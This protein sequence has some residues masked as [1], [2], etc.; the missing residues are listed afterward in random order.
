LK[1]NKFFL[2]NSRFST[3]LTF[4]NLKFM[5]PRIGAHV[6]AAGGLYKA[7]E[8][9]QAIGAECIQIFGASP[10]TWRGVLPSAEQVKKFRSAAAAAG[11][12]HIYLHASYLV[13]LASAKAYNREQS[14]LSL[15]D[16]L[17]IAELLGARGLIFH[18][19]SSGVG[20]DINAAKKYTIEGINKIL[21]AVPA[22]PAGGPGKAKL[23][24]ENSAGGGAKLGLTFHQ[25]GELFHGAAS[26]RLGICF[27]TAHGFEAGLIDDYTPEKTK[28][29]FDEF[30]REI[31]LEHLM[32]LHLNDSKTVFGSHHDRHE[33]LG[34]GQIGF[35]GF[36][37][38]ASDKRLWQADW[39]LEVP[40]F[41]GLGPDKKNADLLKSLFEKN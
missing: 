13:N 39:I 26:E 35:A 11:I 18:L 20:G 29:L 24:L 28:K 2:F 15:I 16:H 41:D 31:G 14:I 33:N 32:V 34:E 7:I 19:G 8:N 30:D 4:I 17:K 3:E 9:A 22:S 38:L 25:I 23:I 37:N 21:K 1:I 36:K 27:D 10:R 6:S 40:G 5:R 12:N